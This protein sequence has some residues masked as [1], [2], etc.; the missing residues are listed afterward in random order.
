MMTGTELS[1]FFFGALV[2]P[3]VLWFSY[4]MAVWIFKHLKKK[5]WI[6]HDWKHHQYSFAA[7]TRGDGVIYTDILIAFDVCKRCGK[8]ILVHIIR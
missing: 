4:L 6:V 3:G 8:S 1:W 7:E 5:C 2:G